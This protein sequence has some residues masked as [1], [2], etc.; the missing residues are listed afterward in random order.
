[1]FEAGDTVIVRRSNGKKQEV[2]IKEFQ[3]D[4]RILVNWKI[5]EPGKSEVT[6]LGKSVERKEIISQP[7]KAIAFQSHGAICSSIFFP[8]MVICVVGTAA[9]C[10]WQEVDA[11]FKKVSSLFCA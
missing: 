5:Q 9:F 6:T 11:N 7:R 8:V 3:D 4:G 1:M 2:F 10:V